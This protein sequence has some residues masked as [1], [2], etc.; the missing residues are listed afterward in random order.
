M[1]LP[2]PPKAGVTVGQLPDNY[3][4]GSEGHDCASCAYGPLG[5]RFCRVWVA[6]VKPDM[7]CNRFEPK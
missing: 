6:I 4:R 5:G 2:W 3:R 1:K 7:L